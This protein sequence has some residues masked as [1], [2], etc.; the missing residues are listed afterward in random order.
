MLCVFERTDQH[1]SQ[2]VQS[3][4]SHVNIS[5][6]IFGLKKIM[7]SSMMAVTLQLSAHAVGIK[8]SWVTLGAL[9]VQTTLT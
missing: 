7:C 9:L 3:S 4:D 1:T 2:V 8:T 5:A 6:I